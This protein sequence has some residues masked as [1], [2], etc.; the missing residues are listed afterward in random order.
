MLSRPSQGGF[1]IYGLHY[2]GQISD[3]TVFPNGYYRR[4]VCGSIA[5]VEVI[6]SEYFA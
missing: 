5:V 6:G 2:G 1:R 3:A 4:I